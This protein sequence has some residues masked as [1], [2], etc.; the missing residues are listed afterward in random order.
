MDPTA[1]KSVPFY[2]QKL[3]S[4]CSEKELFSNLAQQ[5]NKLVEIHINS[6][7][8]ERRQKLEQ[9]TSEYNLI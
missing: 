8:D 7:N 5:K 6:L 1:P 9:N 3:K 4:K 2:R